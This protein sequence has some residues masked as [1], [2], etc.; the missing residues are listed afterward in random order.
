MSAPHFGPYEPQYLAINTAAA[1]TQLVAAVAHRRVKVHGLFL[2]SDVAQVISFVGDGTDAE[3]FSS[4]ITVVTEGNVTP[5]LLPVTEYGW[6]ETGL[7]D[8][9]DLRQ[10]STNNLDGVIVYSVID[11]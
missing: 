7:G 3:I 10:A 5:I 2:S 8:A 4:R 11:Y 6:F 1:D 9:L